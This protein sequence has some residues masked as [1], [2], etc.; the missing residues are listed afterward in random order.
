[1]IKENIYLDNHASTKIDPRVYKKMIPFYTKYFGNPHSNS[2]QH[3]WIMEKFISLSRSRIS[4]SIGCAEEEIFFTSGATESNNLAIKGLALSQLNKRHII[5]C[6]TE[7]RCVLESCR[8]L[9]KIGFKITYLKVDKFGKINLTEFKKEI[10]KDTFLVSLMAVNNEIGV[11][12]PL[13][14]IGNIC[15]KKKILFHTD[16]SQGLGKIDFDVNSLNIDLASFSSHKI[17]GP[18]G[19]GALYIKKKP[20]IKLIPLFSGGGQETG[21]R[22]GTLPPAL[23]IG[24]SYATQLATSEMGKNMKKIKSLKKDFLETLKKEKIQFFLN[25]DRNNTI[26]NNINITF[27]NISGDYLFSKLDDISLSSGS[28]CGSGSGES[29][30]VLKEI[31]LS[32][33]NSQSTVRIGISKDN[34]KKELIYSALK[35]AN[36]IK[37]FLLK[38]NSIKNGK[39]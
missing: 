2:H 28:A 34:T 30:Y 35:I 14:T 29:S 9:E 4:K 24:F 17:H 23:C 26:D 27:P 16:A 25:G 39:N 12:H 37:N 18:N 38:N 6:V 10:K 36:I 1:M 19:I 11:I 7:H 21:L 33:K 22:S 3:G 15:K 5:T 32:N 31:G 8:F 13:K 20:D